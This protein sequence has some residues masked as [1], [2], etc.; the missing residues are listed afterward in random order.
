MKKI[1]KIG[2]LLLSL[3]LTL[4]CTQT[5]TE[6]AD[7]TVTNNYS[8]RELIVSCMVITNGCYTENKTIP[9]GQSK[10]FTVSWD[11]EESIITGSLIETN[12]VSISFWPSGDYSKSQTIRKDIKVNNYKNLDISNLIGNETIGEYFYSWN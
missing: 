4:S 10:T 6:S 11:N 8:G 9:C 2:F 5:I 7:I 1:T 12:E 3:I